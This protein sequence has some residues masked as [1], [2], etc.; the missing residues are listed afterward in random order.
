MKYAAVSAH[1]PKETHT[2][3]LYS[4][5][6]KY[7]QHSTQNFFTNVF[8]PRVWVWSFFGER[9]LAEKLFVNCGEIDCRSSISST[10]HE[11]LFLTKM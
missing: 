3:L 2:N 8:L 7:I 5:I 10:F 9:K 6:I 4:L 1:N 11:K